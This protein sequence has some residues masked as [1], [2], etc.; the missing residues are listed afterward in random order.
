MTR[1]V[2]GYTGDVATTAA[3]PW[4]KE[5][6]RAEV[7][8]VLVDRSDARELEAV[9][10]RALAAGAVRAHVL[11][12]QAV[13]AREFLGPALRAGALQT[14]AM[15]AALAAPI[16]ARTLVEIAAIEQADALAHGARGAAAAR[17]Q[18]AIAALDPAAAVLPVAERWSM[19]HAA[20]LEYARLRHV[21]GSAFDAGEDAGEPGRPASPVT[22]AERASGEPAQ[23][24]QVDV[25]FGRGVPIAVNGIE[26]PL[27]D[28]VATLG[29][30]AGAQRLAD[31]PA[32]LLH[33]A[34]AT[35]EASAEPDAAT[36][37]FAARIAE[38]YGRLIVRGAWYTPLR[39]A[40][41]ASVAVLQ[42][43][44]AGIVRL[45]FRDGRVETSARREDRPTLLPMASR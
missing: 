24:A 14:E 8:A 36:A 15:I 26:M 7:V 10:D 13:F 21:L 40:L 23:A 4:L 33:A 11:D 9:R 25:R 18:A 27:Q 28:L 2:L 35:L 16:V 6:Q 32:V 5:T 44:L 19:D 1:I 42:D 38:D 43:E 39:R 45:T 34:H 41:D 30:I 22:S 31:S 12:V 3:I 29:T 37:A 17:L 20:Q